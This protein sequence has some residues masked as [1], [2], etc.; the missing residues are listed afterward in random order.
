MFVQHVRPG[1]GQPLIITTQDRRAGP[2]PADGAA[3]RQLRAGRQGDQIERVGYYRGLVE[4]IDAPDKTAFFVTPGP[5]I[6]D[7]GVTER[8]YRRCAGEIGAKR[9]YPAGPA[10]KR[11]AQE[12]ERILRHVLVLLLEI[13][14][15]NRAPA[16]GAALTKPFLKGR[17]YLLKGHGAPDRSRRSGSGASGF[18]VCT[19]AFRACELAHTATSTSNSRS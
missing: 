12:H 5:K 7:M 2:V 15:Y 14:L 3:W 1:M 16:C 13:G 6:L 19:K 8:E 11:G 9:F 4:I 17:I 18:E 10:K